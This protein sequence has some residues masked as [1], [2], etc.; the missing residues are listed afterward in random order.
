MIEEYIRRQAR[1]ST[2]TFGSGLRTVGIT[3][4]ITKECAEIR[5]NP[6]DLEEWIDVMIL[7]IDGFWRA[8][9]QSHEL[10]WM[11]IDKQSKNFA[12]Q[13]PQNVPEHLPVEHIKS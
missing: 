5:A 10:M 11:L 8:G 1:W 2:K 9:G 7:A 13:W 12:R 6:Y 3:E 4:H